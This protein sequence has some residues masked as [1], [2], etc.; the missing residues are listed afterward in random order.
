MFP[1]LP[2]VL[3]ADDPLV[4]GGLT[5]LLPDEVPVVRAVGT[6][7]DIAVSVATSGAEAVLWDADHGAP[8]ARQ[9]DVEVPVV[10]LAADVDVAARALG[11]GAR[12]VLQRDADGARLTACLLAVRAG[13]VVVDERFDELIRATHPSGDGPT[14]PLTPREEEVL[15]LLAEGRSNREIAIALD[16]SPHTA[17]FHVDRI[18]LK[19]DASGRTD[20]VVRAVRL[21]ILRL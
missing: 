16:I 8:E 18:L 13:L 20:A 19:L 5:A 14:E 15:E 9:L 7:G 2:I 3:V 1:D 10:V 6:D 17:K 12:A 21:G 4:R 11:A